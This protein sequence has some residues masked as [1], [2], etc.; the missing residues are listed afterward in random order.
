MPYGTTHADFAYGAVP[1]TRDLTAKEIETDYELNT[2]RVIAE[3]FKERKLDY[4][5]VPA[6][7]V[8][9]HGPFT[10]GKDCFDA[11][12]NSVILEEV[13]KMA[14]FSEALGASTASEYIQKK[15]YFRKHGKNAYYGQG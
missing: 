10:W 15:H 12:H 5:A 1:C 8:H 9:S 2:G 4:S 11:V 14:F 13:A 6:V 3:C 7:L